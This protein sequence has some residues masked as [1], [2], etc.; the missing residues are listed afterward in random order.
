MAA[1]IRDKVIGVL[2]GGISAERAVSIK[3]GK[4]VAKALTGAGY[5]VREIDITFDSVSRLANENIDI[6]FIALHGRYGEDGTIQGMLELLRIPYTGSSHTASA[7]AMNKLMAK[8][9]MMINSIRVTPFEALDIAVYKQT[10]GAALSVRPPLVV[11]PVNEGSSIGISIVKEDA[12]LKAAL[13]TAFAYDNVVLVERYIKA[14]EIQVGILNDKALGVIEIIPRTEFY[15]FK[16]KYSDDMAAHVFPAKLPEDIYEEVMVTGL[17][18]HKA[19]GCGG[20][21]RVDM[22]LDEESELYVLEVNTL[23]GMTKSSLLP[24]IAAGVDIP[25]PALCE[26]IAKAAKL[27]VNSSRI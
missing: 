12:G 27:H 22:L 24:E 8:Q 21:T 19:L 25:F 5:N 2:M 16:A 3:S 15:D 1:G 13:D 18:A 14:R 11:K 20:A 23:P 7:L 26:K 9:I 4:A 10:K 17:K 6:A